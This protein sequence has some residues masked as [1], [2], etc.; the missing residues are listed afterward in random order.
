MDIFIQQIL[1]GLVLGSV[2]AIIALGYTMV[3]GILGIINFAHG[4][5]L[6]VG[7]MVA[8]STINVLHNHFPGL[9]N[10]PTLVIGLIVA[11]IVCAIVG[12]VIERAAYRPLRR[13]PRLAPL[14][15]AIGVSILL[16]TLAMMIWSRNP[17]PFPQLISTDPLNVIKATDTSVGAVISATEIT[18][19]VVA[20][21]VMAGLLLLVHKTKLGRA[22]RAIA[23]NPNVASLMGVNPNFVISATFMIGS[24]LAALAG[25]MIASE[26]GNVHFYMG[27]I[28]GMKAFT[29]AVLGGIGNLGGA[30]VGGV[31]LGLIEQLGAGYIGNLTGGVFGSNYQDVFAFIV[32]IIV[33]VFRPSGLL[34]ERVADRA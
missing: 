25:V 13:A 4:D 5:V 1:N 17:L 20:F 16:E 26:Y 3:Y 6:M 12:Y 28:P 15:T 33:L 19:I 32:L 14:I 18:I 2:Y 24:A 34:G 27:F 29:A 23:E 11:A 30:M 21:L 9:G 10:I 8:L 22:M 7:A 31:V